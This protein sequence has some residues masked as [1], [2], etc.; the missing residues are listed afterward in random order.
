MHKIVRCGE[1][2]DER[3]VL[4]ISSVFLT[5]AS[6]QMLLLLLIDRGMTQ[7]LRGLKSQELFFEHIKF[8]MKEL[9]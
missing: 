8:D 6:G 7:E 1:C 2:G 9:D 4:G 3:E 5:W